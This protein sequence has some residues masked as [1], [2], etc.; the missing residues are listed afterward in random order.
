MKRGNSTYLWLFLAVS[1]LWPQH[2]SL[3]IG[4]SDG[5]LAQSD[6]HTTKHVAS[7]VEGNL[8]PF[9]LNKFHFC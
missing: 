2:S 7:Y 1:L 9:P 6:S 8:V 4:S 5:N 3:V